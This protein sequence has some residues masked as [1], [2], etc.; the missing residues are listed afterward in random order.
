MRRI[1]RTLN[2]K[3]GGRERERNL[4]EFRQLVKERSRVDPVLFLIQQT[5][6]MVKRGNMLQSASEQAR[7]KRI[8]AR[9][10]T[11]LPQA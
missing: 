7:D 10:R 1:R 2:T 6:K 11:E 9:F 3:S 5:Q 4:G 8:L